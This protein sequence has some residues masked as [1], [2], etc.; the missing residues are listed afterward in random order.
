[1]EK[2]EKTKYRLAEAV[3][4]CM[5]TTPVEEITVK[6]IASCAGIA[7]QTFYRNFRDREDLINW[8]FDKLL[9]ESFRE[10]GRGG[11]INDGLIRKFGLFP[12]NEDLKTEE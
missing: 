4:E 11:T 6:Q 8:Y 10:M 5:K 9:I 3:K 2:N 1:M 12:E 7:R